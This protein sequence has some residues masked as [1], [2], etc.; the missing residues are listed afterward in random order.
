LCVNQTTI[1]YTITGGVALDYPVNT[2][3][4]TDVN[5]NGKLDG[6]DVQLSQQ[7]YTT[8]G[9]AG[10]FTKPTTA[11][12]FLITVDAPGLCMDIVVPVQCPAGATLPVS[13][14]SF[15]VSRINRNQVSVRWETATEVSNRGFSIERN[16]GDGNWKSVGFVNSHAPDGTSNSLQSYTFTDAVTVT[17]ILQYRLRQ[18]DFSGKAA[19]SEIRS[20]RSEDKTGRTVIYPNPATENQFNISFDETPGLRTVQLL[21]LSGR[22]VKQWNNISNNNLQVTDL[23]PGYYHVRVYNT[24]SGVQTTEKVLVSSH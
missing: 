14:R 4:Y 21:D 22:I 13:L 7:T 1:A 5:G 24:A 19:I 17:G 3:L 16:A 2:T 12:N 11:D 10:F 18:V 6:S 20:L 23:K 9:V 8:A 15:Q